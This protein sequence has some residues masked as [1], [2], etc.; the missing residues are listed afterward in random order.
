MTGNYWTDFLVAGT[1]FYLFHS[2][3]FG[4][5]ETQSKARRHS[6]ITT[7]RS[8]W[9]RVGLAVCGVALCIWV[10]IDLRQKLILR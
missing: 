1:G 7:V 9:M 3:L 2:A 6:I 5:L 8:R 10:G 4:R